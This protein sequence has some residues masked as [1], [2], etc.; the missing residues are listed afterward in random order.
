MP[1]LLKIIKNPNPILRKKSTLVDLKKI[2]E[3]DFKILID[4]MK[5]TML[6]KDGVGLAA[7]Q[8]GKNKRIITVNTKDG[9]IAMINPRILN[10]SF[11]KEWDEEGCLSVPGIYGK[12]KRSKKLK[13]EFFDMDKKKNIISAQGFF[14]RIIQ[15]EIDH[16]DGILFIDKAKDTRNI[17]KKID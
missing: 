17:D 6:K 13:C 16:L 9:V 11:L 14:A 15:H 8:I 7:P 1:K 3:K 2:N 12:V 4:D 10:K 5:E